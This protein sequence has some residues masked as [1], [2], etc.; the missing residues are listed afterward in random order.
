[1][2]ED[3]KLEVFI[4]KLLL[5]EKNSPELQRTYNAF[6]ANE[7]A[8]LK[9]NAIDIGIAVV[10]KLNG[11][12]PD[13]NIIG[14]ISQYL[15]TAIPKLET[16][17]YINKNDMNTKNHDFL[18]DQVKYLGF[19][20]ELKN[21]LT[22]QLKKGEP[23]FSLEFPVE[24]ENHNAIYSL[25]FSKS[26]NN[27]MYF[28]NSFKLELTNAKN[29][30]LSNTF[31]VNGFKGVTAKEALNVLEGRPVKAVIE[32]RKKDAE[33]K[34]EKEVF[35][36]LDKEK[37]P[38]EITSETKLQFKYFS[39]EYGI[40]TAKIL[41]QAPM[42]L[43]NENYREDAIKSLEKGNFVKANFNF[44][45]EDVQGLVSLNA[46]YKSLNYYDGEG[47]SLNSKYITAENI[48]QEHTKDLKQKKD[49]DANGLYNSEGNDFTDQLIDDMEKG[50]GTM[51]QKE[52]N[53]I[54]SGLKR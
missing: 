37:L 25:N 26:K 42:K 43:P 50:I 17:N 22:E 4:E 16:N 7:K 46:Q 54:S 49:P 34:N 38:K 10:E 5:D 2:N 3:A 39:K 47:K 15:D 48:G 40:D 41:E 12:K 45:G 1:M 13:K 44:K 35:I 32:F 24:K 52:N 8:T 21:V 18:Q 11:E 36:Q 6:N 31:Q 9:D 33:E 29:E 28:F 20:E 30:T 27:D 14:N 51:N 19:G 23:S 53:D